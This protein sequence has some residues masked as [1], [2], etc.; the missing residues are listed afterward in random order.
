MIILRKYKQYHSKWVNLESYLD[1]N[2]NISMPYNKQKNMHNSQN[3]NPCI[4]VHSE[5]NEVTLK[6]TMVFIA[7]FLSVGKKN[8]KQPRLSSNMVVV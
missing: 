4:V 7:A 3:N 8:C 2:Y 1:I 5:N 6:W